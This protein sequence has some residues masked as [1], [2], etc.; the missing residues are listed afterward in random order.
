MF[1]TRTILFATV[2]FSAI[3]S[4]AHPVDLSARGCGG[5]GGLSCDTV[6]VSALSQVQPTPSLVGRQACGGQ[7]GPSCDTVLGDS[8]IATAVERRCGGQGQLSCDF[9]IPS[10]SAT[11]KPTPAAIAARQAC[12]GLGRPSCD[13]APSSLP[14]S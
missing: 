13:S 9:I 2:A 4:F 8:I 7:G 5:Q 14:S 10:H 3:V 6:S 1:S 11:V 12:G